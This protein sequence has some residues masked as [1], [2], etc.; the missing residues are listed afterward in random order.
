MD[1]EADPKA[2]LKMNW[3]EL[4]NSETGA[5]LCPLSTLLTT[6]STDDTQQERFDIHIQI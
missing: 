6:D 2:G 5:I 3:D 4:A 1:A